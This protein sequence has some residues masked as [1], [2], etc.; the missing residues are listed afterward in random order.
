[1]LAA[2][3][4][5]LNLLSVYAPTWAS[6]LGDE[7]VSSLSLTGRG[8]LACWFSSFLLI[9]SG[10]AS[11]QIYALR[12][13][14]RDDYRGTYRLWLWM[15]AL[16]LFASL[17]CV[18]DLA[19]IA[20]NLL[21]SYTALT[22]DSRPWLPIAAKLVFLT[23]LVAR[24]LYEVRGSRGTFAL[25][26]FVWIAYSVAAVLQL[27]DVRPELVQLSHETLLGNS[28]LFATAAIFL[29]ELSY[30]RYIYLQAH[31]LIKERAIK[32]R[33]NN[34][35]KSKKKVSQKKK[36]VVANT[37]SAPET[38]KNATSSN[39]RKRTKSSVSNRQSAKSASAGSQPQVRST[40]AKANAAK[41]A[42]SKPLERTNEMEQEGVI[43]LSKSERRRRRKEDK[44]RKA[45]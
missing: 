27:P 32:K 4:G 36:K 19:M 12:Q 25:V 28:L 45:A 29:A 2:M 43:K 7:G 13:H 9:I 31:G 23:T 40:A 21:Q 44:R 11:L 5:L 18:V 6:Q 17:N 8:T 22:I 14:R 10:L 26:V 30:A 35:A 34:V 24:G 41:T 20:T 1:M 15:S 16:L 3:I 38:T 33:S 42:R 39:S 37:Q